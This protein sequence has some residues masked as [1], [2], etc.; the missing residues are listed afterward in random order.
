MI[1]S[2]LRA[3]EKTPEDVG[4]FCVS[5]G[6]GSFTGIRIG[7][8][9]VKGLAFAKNVPCCG[10]STLEAL[11]YNCAGLPDGSIVC[12]V[13]DARRSEFYN[14]LFT[15]ENGSPVRCAPDRAL[16]YGDLF[17][18]LKEKYGSR[19]IT[20]C[21]DGAVKFM[22]M[23]SGSGGSL[24]AVKAC[25]NDL[26]QSGAS[27]ARLGFDMYKRGESVS[28]EALMPEYLRMSQAERVSG[29]K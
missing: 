21:G 12:P 19:R 20:V 17:T 18:E 16:P 9:T 8:S 1:D 27:V 2:V 28:P 6:P 24:P 10:V 13:M 5:R 25:E 23:L 3:A 4:L 11:A 14:A 29:G 26:Y 7:V 22:T 15:M